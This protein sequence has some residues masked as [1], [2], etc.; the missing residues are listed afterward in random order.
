MIGPP[1]VELAIQPQP[2]LKD[3]SGCIFLSLQTEPSA[4]RRTNVD[5]YRIS[6]GTQ[7]DALDIIKVVDGSVDTL[8]DCD[9]K[10]FITYHYKVEAIDR[11][12]QI[13]A[14]ADSAEINPLWVCLV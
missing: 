10:P 11:F 6:R 8:M 13:N 5:S 3:T 2:T 7:P 1:N 14:D 12:G 4:T 9:V